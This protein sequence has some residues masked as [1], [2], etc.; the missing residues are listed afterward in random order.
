MTLE[1]LIRPFHDARVLRG[2]PS[3]EV[4]DITDDSRTVVEGGAFVARRGGA[5][6]GRSFIPEAIRRGAAVVITDVDPE[7]M[8][9]LP[10]S[11]PAEFTEQTHRPLFQDVA[12]VQF[13]QL[14]H[15]RVGELAERFFDHPSRK[16]KLIGI[17][18]TN[19]KT[20]TAYITK[21]LLDRVGAK[22]GLIST[23]VIDDGSDSRPATLTTPGAI[24]FS[25]LLGAMVTHGCQAAV[26]EVSSHA[27]DQDRT[28][29]LAFDVGV[30]TNLTGD[31]LD[32]HGT[33]E[34]YAAAKARLFQQLPETPQ[35]RA[36]INADDPCGP[37]MT[38][39]C[40]AAVIWTNVR[41]EEPVSAP[42]R[43]PRNRIGGDFP[44]PSMS[45]T[46]MVSRLS[47]NG[48]RFRVIGPWG[49]VDTHTPLVGLHNVSNALQAVAAA[50]AVTGCDFQDLC[51][52]LET[53]PPIP[54]RLESIVIDVSSSTAA[55]PA[56][57]VDYA[58]THDAL[59][60]V[61]RALRRV[62]S[63]W[64]RPD[65][66]NTTMPAGKLTVIFGA[67]GDRDRAKRPKMAA[68]A[69]DLADRI[70]ITSDNPRTEDP[71]TII[72]QILSGVPASEKDRVRV[73]PDRAEAIATTIRDAGPDDLVLIAGKGHEDYQII[74]TEKHTFDDRV[75]AMAALRAMKLR[76]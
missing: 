5:S 30:F 18:G 41:E 24:E 70:V 61:L 43:Q 25:G 48:S 63:M 20:T 54:G 32:Y 69:C 8:K 60:N 39:D 52:A 10:D 51:R 4:R 33:P 34:R 13:S 56:V 66:T 62:A 2:D 16:I 22:C 3:V 67:G 37:R 50:H 15:R 45:I 31:H 75:E 46:A 74:G 73:V 23:V 65:E 26:A 6:D 7:D 72:E 64:S 35:A 21:H 40:R 38:R 12:W 47:A 29:A 28:G 27:L 59:E 53:C 1:D 71:M 14:D 55:R 68:V 42:S 11:D 58:H 44:Q 19:G 49:N 76:T 17:T 9:G 36:V 57:I